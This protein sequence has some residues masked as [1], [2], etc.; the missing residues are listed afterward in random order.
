MLNTGTINNINCFLLLG[1]NQGDTYEL[2]KKTISILNDRIGKIEA[3]SHI[4]ETEA[5]GRTD[6]P[7]FINQAIKVLIKENKDVFTLLDDLQ[8]IELDMGRIRKER[9][10]PRIIDIDILMLGNTIIN[11][12]SLTIP[13]K[14]L[15]NRRF[16]LMPL[17]DIAE[18]M[19]HPVLKLRISELL[20]QCNDNLM[21]KR[22]I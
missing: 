19:I 2:L 3:I 12:N 13:H 15:A 17:C 6:Q 22:V 8:Q 18:D 5:W 1:S 20:K 9:W 10:S 11:E 14:E 4:Y 7:N 21:V 16:A